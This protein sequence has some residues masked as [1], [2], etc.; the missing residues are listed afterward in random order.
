VDGALNGMTQ[1]AAIAPGRFR[2][3]LGGYP[4]GVCVITSAD[5]KSRYAMVVGS[6]TSISLEPPMVGFFP[7]KSST[8]WPKIEGTGRFCV[9]VLGKDQLDH[10]R[11]FASKREDKFEG[12]SHSPSP[13]GL[14]MLDD[15]I[16]WIE[17]DIAQVTEIGDHLLVVGAVSAL[18]RRD[19]GDPLLFFSGAYHGLQPLAQK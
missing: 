15:A 9:N 10:C 7:D 12:R 3:V 18:D 8:S 2:E 14:P 17:C 5:A 19:N 11:H 16:A 13:G 4:T 1:A 6:F